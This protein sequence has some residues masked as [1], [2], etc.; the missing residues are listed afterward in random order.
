[1]PSTALIGVRIS[2]DMFARNLP[3]ASFAASASCR[4]SSA[5][6][7]ASASCAFCCSVTLIFSSRRRALCSALSRYSFESCRM[8]RAAIET[9]Y[10]V[11]PYCPAILPYMPPPITCA[12]L[13]AA[14]PNSSAARADTGS[15]RY[16]RLFSYPDCIR[17]T[18]AAAQTTL[19]AAADRI[20]IS[21]IYRTPSICSAICSSA[22]ALTQPNSAEKRRG[23]LVRRLCSWYSAKNSGTSTT[24]YSCIT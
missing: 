7:L 22:L 24:R 17:L 23:Y 12:I 15:S 19:I 9:L 8:C 3:F 18:M 10:I 4:A 2:W 5:S 21:S 11:M 1:M 16:R 13:S 20:T 14:T 6:F